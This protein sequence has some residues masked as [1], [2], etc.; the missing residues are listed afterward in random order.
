MTR[1][2]SKKIGMGFIAFMAVAMFA[3]MMPLVCHAETYPLEAEFSPNIINI[4]SS[5][6]GEI[7]VLT[8]MSYATFIAEGDG[9]F[10]YFNLGSESL[11][12]IQA[13]RDSLGHLI[14]RFALED[15]LAVASDLLVDDFNIADVVLVMTNGD[16]YAGNYDQLYIVDKM[17]PLTD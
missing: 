15:L 5:H 17:A 2:N 1:R 11:P 16:E 3:L 14:L 9:I 12:N 4:A 7:R 10:I 8:D 13:T 6:Y